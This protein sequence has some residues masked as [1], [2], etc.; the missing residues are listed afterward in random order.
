MLFFVALVAATGRDFGP[1][2]RAE[3]R[4]RTTGKVLGDDARVDAATGEGADIAPAEGTPRRAINAIVPVLVLVGGVVAGLFA[5]GEGSTVRDIIGSADSYKALMWASLLGV[6]VAGALAVG[7]RI[8]TLE[9]V[10]D[11]WFAG[12]RAMLLAMIILVLAWALSAVTEQLHTGDFLGSALAGALAPGLVPAVVFVLAALLAFATGTSWGTMGI[13]MPLV[14]PVTW[15][16]LGANGAADPAHYYV[17][18][19]AVS[20]V[21]AGAV[22]GDHCSPISDTTVL[23]STASACDHI[24]HVRTQLPYA[25]VVGLAGLLLGTVPS[26]F[27]VP[28]WIGM[29][30]AAA[31][32]WA[33]L[34]YFGRPVD[35]GPVPDEG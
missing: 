32:V 1:M 21:L 22:W 28:W 20:C 7:Q 31:A 27:G 11:A 34:R 29:L 33:V 3:R 14:V 13:L 10:S 24:A 4:A 26:G 5:T 17:I 35:E 23:S 8:L 30:A 15:Q 12:L 2:R 19:A 25:M 16:I 6:L 18:Y 9:Q